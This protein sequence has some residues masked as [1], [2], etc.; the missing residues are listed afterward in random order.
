MSEQ[1]VEDILKEYLKPIQTDP[2][3]ESVLI[4]D[5]FES[6]EGLSAL[7]RVRPRFNESY[8]G[9][10]DLGLNRAGQPTYLKTNSFFHGVPTDVDDPGDLL[11]EGEIRQLVVVTL[12]PRMRRYKGEVTIVRAWRPSQRVARQSRAPSIVVRGLNCLPLLLPDTQV[13]GLKRSR[14][15][16]RIRGCLVVYGSISEALTLSKGSLPTVSVVHGTHLNS[17]ATWVVTG[18][19]PKGA[20][21]LCQQ[22]DASDFRAERTICSQRINDYLEHQKA[23]PPDGLPERIESDSEALTT[24]VD[25]FDCASLVGVIDLVCSGAFN[26]LTVS[27]IAAPREF[28]LFLTCCVILSTFPTHYR[29]NASTI[30]DRKLSDEMVDL[31]HLNLPPCDVFTS[32]TAIEIAIQLAIENTGSLLVVPEHMRRQGLALLAELLGGHVQGVFN[33]SSIRSSNRSAM[34]TYVLKTIRDVDEWCHTGIYLGCR[35]STENSEEENCQLVGVCHQA[36]GSVKDT[37][38]SYFNTSVLRL[39]NVAGIPFVACRPNTRTKCGMCSSRFDV[40]STIFKGITSSCCVCAAFFC[41]ACHEAMASAFVASDQQKDVVKCVQC[42][43]RR[44][45]LATTQIETGSQD[46]AEQEH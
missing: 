17:M 41:D 21:F 34:L 33:P 42:Q 45:E 3:V 8:G 5:F 28:P 38:L 27:M 18:K 13:A 29:L 20:L 39:A 4:Q 23:H 14:K 43:H 44:L 24:A 26:G 37:L 7:S 46:Q 35:E 2:N 32:Q 11:R 9:W 22:I 10:S 16:V 6:N 30:E 1:H 40:R 19:Q 15:Q 31:I 36:M 12:D 25:Y